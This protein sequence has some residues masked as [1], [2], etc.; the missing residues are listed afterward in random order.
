MKLNKIKLYVPALAIVAV[1][2]MTSCVNDLDVDPINPQQTMEFDSDAL[3]NKIYASFS[4]TGQIGPSDNGDV[5]DIDEGSS[6]FYRMGWY[7]NEF[8]TDEASW[9]WASDA[10]V[11]DLLHNTYGAANDFSVGMYYRLY[12]TITLCN[13]YLNQVSGDDTETLRRIAEVR[14]IRALNYYYVMDLYG[15]AA[16][17]E[18]VGAELA[19]RYT[20]E[21]YYEYIESELLAIEDDLASAGSNTYGRV[22]KVANW[23]LLSRLYLNAE[24]YTGTAQWQKAL[25][26]ANQ[27]INNGYYKLLTQG[28]TN[29]STGEVYSAYQLLFLG[30][31]DTNGAQYEA[32]FPVLCDGDNTSSYG[33]STFLVLGC[34]GADEDAAVP[35]GTDASWGKCTR[36]RRQLLDQFYGSNAA[37]ESLAPNGSTVDEMTSAANDDRALFYGAGYTADTPDESDTGGGFSCVKF[38]SVRSDGGARSSA[39]YMSDSDIPL[40][41]VAEAYL[42]YAEASTRLNGVNSDAK[43]KLDALRNRANASLQSTYTLEDILSEW[44]KEFWFEGRRR[45]DLV[46]YGYYGGQSSYKWEWM[47]GTYAGSQFSSNRN[48]F[49]IPENDL[50]NNSNLVQ[51]P[52]Y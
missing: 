48:I 50:A 26:Y 45:I 22:D 47:G 44:S 43:A 1:F 23:L 5:A 25:D 32:I 35:S 12:F 29:P 38:R 34:Y 19:E 20:R 13:F 14:F 8:T 51:N 49:G 31:N 24:V 42:T 40:F 17:T 21:Q 36:V 10:G 2:G 27:V 46:R 18:K 3:F 16:F 33:N 41:R 11:P 15:N 9:V 6:A 37:G 39:L 4:L 7:M 30:D 28:A 52:G